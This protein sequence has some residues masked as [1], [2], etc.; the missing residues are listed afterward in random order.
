MLY[1][2]VFINRHDRS[3]VDHNF[4]D[5]IASLLTIKCYIMKKRNL[6]SLVLNKKSISNLDAKQS[7]ING[8]I[9]KTN[10]FICSG[11]C[12]VN[13]VYCNTLISCPGN[14]ICG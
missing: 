6:T 14:G 7:S 5:S 12:S 13:P 3:F 1:T 8:G 11:Q 2:L 10:A 4:H 9:N